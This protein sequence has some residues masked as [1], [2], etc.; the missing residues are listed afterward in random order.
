MLYRD[1][2]KPV[3]VTAAEHREG[4]QVNLKIRENNIVLSIYTQSR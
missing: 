4:T 2:I 1:Q 3:A